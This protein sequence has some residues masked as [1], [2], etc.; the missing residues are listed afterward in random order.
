MTTL[1]LVPSPRVER[2][3]IELTD[4]CSKA[5][6]FCY[7][8]AR[9]EG[10]RAWDPDRVVALVRDC[11]RHGTRAVSFG[12]GEPLE[13]PHLFDVL[14][15]TRGVLFRSLTTNGLHLEGALEALS[16]AAP[17]KVHV[18]VHQP[19]DPAEVNRAVRQVEALEARGIRGGVNLLVRRSGLPA[20]RAAGAALR[21]A[22]VGPDRVVWL[23]MRPA[24]TPSAAELAEAAGGPFQSATC[25]TG[26]GPSP[27]FASLAVDGSVA[28]C[29]YTRSRAPLR[30]P[31]HAALAEAL[32]IAA[33]SLAPCSG[34]SP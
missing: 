6:A 21:R 31:T 1:R 2:L 14:A 10:G 12:G 13:Y 27:R 15:A 3:S 19:A 16:R 7:A 34:G 25:I 32:A 30:E 20:A 29:S 24:D 9:P 22:G 8:G 23:P 5:C 26:C 17:E 11:A 18:S 4:R 33:A 28:P